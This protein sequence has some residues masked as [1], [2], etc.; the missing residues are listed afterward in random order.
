MGETTTITVSDEVWE[1]LDAEKRRNQS[2]DELLREKLGMD[3]A[4]EPPTAT[5]QGGSSQ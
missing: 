3:A 2:F 4:H 1:E 5:E